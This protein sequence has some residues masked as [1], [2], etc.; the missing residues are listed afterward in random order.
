MIKIPNTEFKFTFSRSSGS[1][2][3]NINK[4][5]TK[6]TLSWD[7][8]SSTT[9]PVSVKNRF[10]IRYKR[11]IVNNKVIITSQKYRSQAQNIDDCICKLHELLSSVEFAPKNR[12]ATKP[13]RASIR[14]RLDSK[15]RNSSKKK[16]RSEK[17]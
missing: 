17:F 7:M 15:K 9:C 2:G 3:Q 13:T 12:R 10:Q 1:G 11:F 6:S 16:L 8:D 4:V 14:K 5:N